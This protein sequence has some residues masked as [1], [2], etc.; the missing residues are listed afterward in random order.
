MSNK[1]P[2]EGEGRLLNFMSVQHVYLLHGEGYYVPTLK[3]KKSEGSELYKMWDSIQTQGE[4]LNAWRLSSWILIYI[5]S[6]KSI[7]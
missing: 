6:V 7:T 4:A 1:N 3:K 2:P 5:I